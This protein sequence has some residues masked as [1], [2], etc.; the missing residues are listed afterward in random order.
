MNFL[1][2]GLNEVVLFCSSC[3]A[4]L[5]CIF[6]SFE[7][8]VFGWKLIIFIYCLCCERNIWYFEHFEVKR[9]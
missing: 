9:R 5:I 1:A 2:F 4:L 7:N 3:C 8:F 6:V